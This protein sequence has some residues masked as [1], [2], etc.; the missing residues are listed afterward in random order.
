M[1]QK[2]S[3]S[4]SSVSSHLFKYQW[5]HLNEDHCHCH[6]FDDMLEEMDVHNFVAPFSYLIEH[7]FLQGFF[8]YLFMCSLNHNYP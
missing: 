5:S 1:I 6:Y 7:G 3:R 2:S 4:L 8:N